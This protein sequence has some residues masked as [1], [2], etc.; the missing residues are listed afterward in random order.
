MKCKW[1][2]GLGIFNIKE[3]RLLENLTAII[4]LLKGYY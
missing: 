1:L 4:K 3:Q 2:K